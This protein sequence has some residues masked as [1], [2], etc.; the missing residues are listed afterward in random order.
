MSK[1]IVVC[2]NAEV[3]LLE[4]ANIVLNLRYYTK[5]WELHYGETKLQKKNY[6]KKADQWLSKHCIKVN[7]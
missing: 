3:S 7:E 1:H 5:E 6:E 4:L 2:E